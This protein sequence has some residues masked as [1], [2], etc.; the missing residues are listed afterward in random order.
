MAL[1]RDA[2]R[3]R[4]QRMADKLREKGIEPKDWPSQNLKVMTGTLATTKGD[5]AVTTAVYRRGILAKRSDQVFD[6]SVHATI[7]K[8]G[9]KRRTGGQVGAQ[10]ICRNVRELHDMRISAKLP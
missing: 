1:E 5:C 9:Q 3:Q 10:Q 6:S 7:D 4:S 2:E 8:R